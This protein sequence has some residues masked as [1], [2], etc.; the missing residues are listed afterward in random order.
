MLSHASPS[1]KILGQLRVEQ[2]PS[3]D[4]LQQQPSLEHTFNLEQRPSLA[5]LSFRLEQRPS[6]TEQSPAEQSP[7]FKQPLSQGPFTC[8]TRPCAAAT[9]SNAR[10]TRALPRRGS[11]A[12]HLAWTPQR[13]LCSKRKPWRLRFNTGVR[14]GCELGSLAAVIHLKN[15]YRDENIYQYYFF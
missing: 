13:H 12:L 10:K 5:D 14:S 2:R 1:W 4:R 8:S 15:K 11:A 3:L 9:C 6:L 7:S